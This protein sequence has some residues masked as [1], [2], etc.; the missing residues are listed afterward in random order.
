DLLNRHR[1]DGTLQQV[2]QLL[3]DAGLEE[4][5]QLARDIR[6]DDTDRNFRE[7]QLLNLPDS[8][9]AA[10]TERSGYDW[11]SSTAQE[12]FD[13][14]KDLLGC[15]HLEQWVSGMKR[16]NENATDEDRAEIYEMLNE[17][18]GLLDKHASGEDTQQDLGDFMDRHGDQFPENP[19]N[20]DEL[21]DTLAERS[22]A[23][24]RMLASMS[25]EQRQELMELSNQAFGSPE[26]TDQLSR[27]D[28]NLQGLR[29]DA[30]WTGAEQF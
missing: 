8:P 19:Q 4:R 11:Q 7:M 9:A 29:P 14:I 1:L 26:L 2:R 10:V 16:A 28:A 5:K 23:A 27:L 20:I 13:Q 30:D 24:Q 6:M 17:I 18:N 21:I 22:A 15:K 12:K 3:D 25:P